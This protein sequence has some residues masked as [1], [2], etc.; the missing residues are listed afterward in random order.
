MAE[1]YV[2]WGVVWVRREKLTQT[3]KRV[4]REK[5][6]EGLEIY[7]YSRFK[8]QRLVGNSGCGRGEWNRG[9][10][11]LPKSDNGPGPVPWKSCAGFVCFRFVGG[12]P[13]TQMLHSFFYPADIHR[14]NLRTSTV[15]LV[16]YCLRQLCK[17]QRDAEVRGQTDQTGWHTVDM[18]IHSLASVGD[19]C[20]IFTSLVATE[21][22]LLSFLLPVLRLLSGQSGWLAA[23]MRWQLLRLSRLWHTR[24]TSSH[25]EVAHHA[26]N[27][28][29]V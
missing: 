9:G 11:D 4:E 15:Q 12:S 20:M 24:R 14:D 29:Q 28:D 21:T 13:E 10:V 25:A 27:T 8:Q 1:R 2:R 17:W 26:Q 3:A 7:Y 23:C 22:L 5:V 18:R 16:L 19:T 6:P